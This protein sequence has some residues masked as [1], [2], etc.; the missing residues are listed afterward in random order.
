MHA[1]QLEHGSQAI[2]LKAH[3]WSTRSKTIN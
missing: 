2:V 1:Q 3:A